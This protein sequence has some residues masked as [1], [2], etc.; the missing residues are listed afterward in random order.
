[1]MRIL[2]P[3]HRV[4]LIMVILLTIGLGVLTY[5]HRDQLT[6]ESLVAY[7]RGIN[8]PVFITLF[9][10]LPLVGFP[11]SVFLFLLGIRFGFTTGMGITAIGMMLHHAVAYGGGWPI[12]HP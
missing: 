10:F 1:M 2:H 9:M 11:V 7:G 4:R 12:C 6:R 3:R 5:I 8:A